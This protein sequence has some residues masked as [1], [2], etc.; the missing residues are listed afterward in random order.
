MLKITDGMSA[1]ALNA[2]RS[3]KSVEAA[4]KAV[5]AAGSKKL[6][7]NV[8]A[9]LKSM[10]TFGKAMATTVENMGAKGPGG[11]GKMVQWI[12]KN[13]GQGA[14][15]QVLGLG[16]SLASAD[17]ALQSVGM[18]LGGV[19]TGGAVAAVAAIT[20]VAV[21]VGL[22]VFKLA[23]MAINGAKAFASMVIERGRFRED[24]M[25][26]LKAMLKS[27]SEAASVFEAATK[28]AKETPFKTD[29]V[30]GAFKDLLAGGF[31]ADE[32]EG[33]MRSIGD[34]AAVVGQDRIPD[35]VRSLSKLR[36]TGKLSQEIL[37]PL[38]LDQK[39]LAKNAGLDDV[40]KLAGLDGAK[41][42]AAIKKTIED[43]Y[44][45]ALKNMSGTLTGMLSNVGD[46]WD[47]LID[48][49]FKA[50]KDGG[51]ITAFFE[52]VKGGVKDMLDAMSGG[53]GTA[54]VT[55]FNR[56]GDALNVVATVLRGFLSGLLGGF[57]D[58]V[59]KGATQVERLSKADLEKLGKDARE[60]GQALGKVAGAA[61]D[62]ATIMPSMKTME[63][64]W[65]GVKIA[66][67]GL[68][69]VLFP[70]VMT[71]GSF[72]APIVMLAGTIGLAIIGIGAALW[73]MYAAAKAV[74]GVVW[75]I[76][77]P[78]VM[79]AWDGFASAVSNAWAQIT[80]AFAPVIDALRPVVAQLKELIG[81]IASGIARGLSGPFMAGGA[82][83]VAVLVSIAY[84][85]VAVLKVATWVINTI[86]S[87][88]DTV[89]SAFAAVRSAVGG[90]SLFNEAISIGKSLIDGLTA[91]VMGGVAAA[92]GAAGGA[93]AAMANAARATTKTHSPSRVF[94]QIGGFMSEGLAQGVTRK[95]PVASAAV[96]DMVS[97]P[98]PS[99]VA[100]QWSAS[101]A[102]SGGGTTVTIAEGA[103]VINA[104]T[105]DAQDIKGALLDA[106]EGIALQLNG[107]PA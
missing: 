6:N 43:M 75:Q 15:D 74:G 7:S 86:G 2:A 38:K 55:L 89:S 106:F 39:L 76:V 9:K 12:G 48:N 58:G 77:G 79:A 41:A 56:L 14:A 11:F 60:V 84:S 44:G 94:E 42:E 37:E 35:L 36:A 4:L 28:F 29:A 32:L 52:T 25:A 50:S 107:A 95:A 27:D 103:I 65:T 105:G 59:S 69:V 64:I 8:D 88:V 73:G 34:A 96:A 3:L 21:A 19:V 61:A 5:D 71:L 53:T 24:T 97:P 83:V 49:A 72:M 51:G 100:G 70:I 63:A 90:I 10:Q 102:G 13:F 16:K 67:L 91:G 92:A 85:L 99:S 33:W 31:K 68:G 47:E 66:V 82:V 62:I 26:Q 18:S 40:S 1:P 57:G 93:A 104:P 17:D 87:I 45:G 23:E 20:A 101:G 30:V 54:A 98:S 78:S 80:T 46:A 22:V 81:P